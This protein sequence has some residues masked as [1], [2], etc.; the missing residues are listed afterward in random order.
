MAYYSKE[1]KQWIA[2]KISTQEEIKYEEESTCVVCSKELCKDRVAIMV[3]VPLFPGSI[4][5]NEFLLCLDDLDDESI[6]WFRNL[7]LD[8]WFTLVEWNSVDSKNRAWTL[9]NNFLNE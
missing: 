8:A 4:Y 5:L 7:S 3:S 6:Q 2:S 1:D 9:V